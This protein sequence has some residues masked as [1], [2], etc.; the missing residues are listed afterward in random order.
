MS[1]CEWMNSED[2]NKYHDNEWGKPVYDDD[3]LFEFLILEGMQAG[4]SW[5]TIL[6]R[7]E[8]MRQAFD[9]FNPQ[10]LAEYDHQKV[11]EFMKN[12]GV[13]RNRLKLTALKINATCFLEVQ[14]EYGSFSQFIWNFVNHRPII[15]DLEKSDERL[16]VSSEAEAMSQS[17]K[18]RGFKF[19]GPTI[20]YAYMQAMGLVNDHLNGCP[21]K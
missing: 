1:R 10:K 17:L 7:R 6:K 13:I 12:P 19:V 18:K 21:F 3:I 2:E 14:K 4:L 5:S 8:T 11:A 9:H 15:N 16:I 20:C